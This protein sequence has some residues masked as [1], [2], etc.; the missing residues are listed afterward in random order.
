M[1]EPKDYA[2]RSERRTN[3]TD[4]TFLCA[5]AYLVIGICIGWLAHI[6]WGLL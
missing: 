1:E 6:I 5:L 3:N 2:P 4:D